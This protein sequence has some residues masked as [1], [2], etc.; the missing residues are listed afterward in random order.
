MLDLLDKDLL[1]G[2]YLSRRW[3]LS[4]REFNVGEKLSV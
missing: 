3:L 4:H 2:G 1:F